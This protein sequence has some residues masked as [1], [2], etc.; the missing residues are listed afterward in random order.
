MEVDVIMSDQAVQ[1]LH[2][3]ENPYYCT[4][5][6]AIL[7][8]NNDS[9]NYSIETLSPWKPMEIDYNPEE[10]KGENRL[11]TEVT[12]EKSENDVEMITD[13]RDVTQTFECIMC[14]NVIV[15]DGPATSV[16]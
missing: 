3:T 13:R 12:L 16:V 7:E 14:G 4:T 10:V 8:R 2:E 6:N 5:C 15:K 1:I 9:E 11:V